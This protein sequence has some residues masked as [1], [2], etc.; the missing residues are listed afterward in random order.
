VDV[1]GD[2]LWELLLHPGITMRWAMSI[3]RNRPYSTL[4][5]FRE[6]SGVTPV[7]LP[8]GAIL[9]PHCGSA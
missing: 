5:A 3:M 8:D 4:T 2:E 9:L 6:K 1:N 7:V